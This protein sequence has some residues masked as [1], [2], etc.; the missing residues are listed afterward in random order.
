MV[1]LYM[2]FVL[3]GYKRDKGDAGVAIALCNIILEN[4]RN[5]KDDNNMIGERRKSVTTTGM[6][7][8][9]ITNNKWEDNVFF[10]MTLYNNILENENNGKCDNHMIGKREEQLVLKVR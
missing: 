9:Q 8:W 5:A 4:E 7:L 2:W 6:P 10:V 1:A 3:E